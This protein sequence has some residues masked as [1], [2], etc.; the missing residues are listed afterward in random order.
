[1]AGRGS[2]VGATSESL[3]GPAGRPPG[4]RVQLFVRTL[5][6]PVRWRLLGSNNREIG[7]GVDSFPDVETCRLAVKD[8][9]VSI[10]DVEAV[11]R[12]ADAHAWVWRVLLDGRPVAAS[13]H[14]YDRQIRCDRGLAQ[15]RNELRLAIIAPE[16]MTSYARRWGRS[17]G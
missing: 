8:L 12:R 4:C 14:G 9:Q 3:T 5:Q 11:V 7:R 6:E 16:V 2:R 1:M 13:S 17:V 10:D 15:F